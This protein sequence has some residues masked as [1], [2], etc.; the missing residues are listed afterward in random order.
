MAFSMLA[1][2]PASP[3][4]AM[5][6]TLPAS[7]IKH[8]VVLYEENR[9]FDHFFGFGKKQLGVDGLNGDEYNLLDP[10]DPTSARATVKPT[11]PWVADIQPNHGYSAYQQKLDIVDH[12]PRMDAFYK[13]EAKSH[14][15][16][17]GAEVMEGFDPKNLPVS[18][19]LA[20]EYAVFDKWYS[21]FPGPSW[22]NH[23][24]SLLATTAGCTNTGD[25]YNCGPKAT[26]T[27]PGRSIFD[28]MADAG[29]DFKYIYNDSVGELYIDRFNAPEFKPHVH[30]MDEF[31]HDAAAGTLPA[32]T[33]IHPREGVNA[34]LGKLGGP[35][36]DH[37]SCCDVALGERLR[38]DIYEAV[39]APPG[40]EPYSP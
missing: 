3:A 14:G 24:Y 5:V 27:Y 29:H 38:K 1:G 39:R 4:L 18:F 31:F 36:S 37:P 17:Q 6:A 9:G 40:L 15:Q 13:F 10:S 19:T 7:P 8:V 16:Q 35:N 21:A 2:A 11:A 33:W 20:Q 34:S 26:A 25:G 22:P 32:L 23:L 28:G 12:K 30:N